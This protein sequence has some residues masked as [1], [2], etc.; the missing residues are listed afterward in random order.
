[1]PFVQ[2]AEALLE[3]E[4]LTG[5]ELRRLIAGNKNYRAKPTPSRQPK[6]DGRKQLKDTAQTPVGGLANPTPVSRV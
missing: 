3:H 5:D 4:T 6:D 1:M 2:I